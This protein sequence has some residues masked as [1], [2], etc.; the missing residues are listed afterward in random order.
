MTTA[1]D[2][3]QELSQ[4]AE[5]HGWQRRELDRVDIYRRDATQVHVLWRGN[6]AISGGSRHEDYVLLSYTRDLG[7]IQG[8]LS[9]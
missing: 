4:I 3:R 8:W 9:A 6:S 5:Q 1:T 2:Q 7:R